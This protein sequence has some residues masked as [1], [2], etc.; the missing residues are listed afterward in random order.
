MIRR[1]EMVGQEAVMEEVMRQ[2]RREDDLGV[3][4]AEAQAQAEQLHTR[5][6]QR[7]RSASRDR[8]GRAAEQ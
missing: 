8:P 2:A 3:F 7:R 4:A 1:A 6:R 5:E